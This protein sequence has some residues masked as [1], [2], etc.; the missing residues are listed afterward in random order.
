MIDCFCQPI[1]SDAGC[2]NGKGWN[3]PGG[4][5][6]GGYVFVFASVCV[7]RANKYAHSHNLCPSHSLPLP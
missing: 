6:G 1:K 4:S 7:W 3:M 5:R 2:V